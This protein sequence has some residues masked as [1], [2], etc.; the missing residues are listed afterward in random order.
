MNKSRTIWC[1]AVTMAK[2]WSAAPAKLN[3]NRPKCCIKHGVVHQEQDGGNYDCIWL[4][5]IM[6]ILIYHKDYVL[7]KD[8]HH[9]EPCLGC[10]ILSK[11]TR[12]IALS[13]T[14]ICWIIIIFYFF[15]QIFLT[16]VKQQKTKIIHP[17]KTKCFRCFLCFSLYWRF[18]RNFSIIVFYTIYTS[19]CILYLIS[20]QNSSFN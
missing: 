5:E 17:T 9:P 6:S 13:P 8:C 4:K 10:L 20:M 19:I 7:H 12:R 14:D 2:Q 3:S 18:F 1:F 16:K 15:Y 11:V